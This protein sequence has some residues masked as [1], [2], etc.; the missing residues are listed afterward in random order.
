[1]FGLGQARRFDLVVTT[2]G[3]PPASDIPG[4]GWHFAFVPIAEVG[5]C[6]DSSRII[7]G[8]QPADG[9]KHFRDVNSVNAGAEPELFRCQE[10]TGAASE[11]EIQKGIV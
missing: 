7:T 4:P 8:V 11:A 10:N 5:F 1:M 6:Q 2:S 3:L 9:T